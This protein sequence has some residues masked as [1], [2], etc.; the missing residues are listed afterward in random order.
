M[1]NKLDDHQ[2][3]A[4]L[5]KE[6]L[7]E[8]KIDGPETME[9][10]D[11]LTLE[12]KKMLADQ[13]PL[14]QKR[15]KTFGWMNWR[16]GVATLCLSL[17]LLSTIIFP[18]QKT[19]AHIKQAV[20]AVWKTYD[21]HD[22][23][24]FREVEVGESQERRDEKVSLEV[25]YIPEGYTIELDQDHG[26]RVDKCFEKGDKFIMITVSIAKS[27]KIGWD[28]EYSTRHSMEINGK[29][30]DYIHRGDTYAFLWLDGR[31][32][33]RITSNESLEENKKIIQSIK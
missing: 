9:L 16:V 19:W 25:G 20:I 2:L 23:V 31:W 1:K 18:V 12:L 17:L 33:Y 32:A 13:D 5:F 7:E 14:P 24:T 8:N 30:I 6:L 26:F 11:G 27:A 22:E 21:D 4:L 15:K 3:K 10:S 28:N 29:H